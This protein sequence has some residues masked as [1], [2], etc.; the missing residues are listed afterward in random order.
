MR[1]GSTN[2]SQAADKA[3]EQFPTSELVFLGDFKAHHEPWLGSTRT[4]YAGRSVHAFTLT[5]DLTQLLLQPTRMPEILSRAPFLLDLL[6]TSPPAEYS[7]LRAD[8]QRIA[9]L[10]QELVTYSTGVRKTQ[11][12]AKAVQSNSCQPS[13]PPLKYPN[14]SLAHHPY[15]NGSQQ[16]KAKLL[17]DLF[18]ANSGIDDRG[19]HPPTILTYAT[20]IRDMHIRLSDVRA[21]LRSPDVRKA[22]GREVKLIHLSCF[23]Y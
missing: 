6:L 3:Q 16:E 23:R 21:E 18:A 22:S 10:G 8:A 14:G 15:P 4:D 12:L 17:N 2:L 7:W 19:K 13:I 5:H 20:K 11:Q 1:Q 9:R